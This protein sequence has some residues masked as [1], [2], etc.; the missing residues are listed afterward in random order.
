MVAMKDAADEVFD[1]LATGRLDIDMGYPEVSESSWL[2]VTVASEDTV[3]RVFWS[4][5]QS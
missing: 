1:F 4:C 3:Y 2:G 5:S